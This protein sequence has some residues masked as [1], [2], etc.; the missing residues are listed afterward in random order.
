MRLL[1]LSA[2]VLAL[3]ACAVPPATAGPAVV[4]PPAHAGFDYQIGGPYP[5]AADV[6]VVTRDHEVAPAPG[7]Y[8][9]CYVNAFQVQPGAEAEWDADLL[10]RD[11]DGEVVYD[12]DWGEALLDL[13]TADKRARVADKVGGWIDG[14][15]AKG[16]Q[17]VEPDNYDSYTRAPEGLLTRS[18]RR[19]CTPC[20]PPARTARG[21]RSRRRTPW[22]WPVT[23]RPSGWTSRSPRSAGSTRSA[24]TTWRRSATT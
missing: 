2:V 22:S 4:L 24:A 16:Y 13:R 19:R 7:L 14:C 12:G 10:L 11:A 6:R 18:T 3:T 17:A 23:G 1:T 5:P 8:N 15:A 21:W 9:I 20:C